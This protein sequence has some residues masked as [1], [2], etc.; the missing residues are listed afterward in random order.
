M[1]KENCQVIIS[2]MLFE[3]EPSGKYLYKDGNERIIEDLGFD[4][5]NIMRLIVEIE[6]KF[7]IT[8]DEELLLVHSF[9]TVNSLVELVQSMVKDEN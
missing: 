8:F 7:K 1:L 5:I 6:N 4:S 9:V 3:I 2:E